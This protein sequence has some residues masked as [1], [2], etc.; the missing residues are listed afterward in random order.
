MIIFMIDSISFISLVSSICVILFTIIIIHKNS[1]WIRISLHILWN[2]G[3]ILIIFYSCVLYFLTR[4]DN[5]IYDFLYLMDREILKTNT[6]IFFNKCLNT[7]ESDLK[8]VLYLYD[9]NSVLIDIDRYYKNIYPILNSLTYFE[10]EIP[11]LDN[12]K[13]ISNNFNKYLN[14]YKLSTNATYEYS[15]INFVLNEISKITNNSKNNNN[16]ENKNDFFCESNDI[17]VSSKAKCKDFKYI[18][19]YDLHNKLERKKE[20][21]YCFIIQDNYQPSDLELIYGNI[22]TK[23]AYDQL[24]N[25]IMGLTKYYN[26]NENLLNSLEK[27]FKELERYNKKLSNITLEQINICKK[28]ISELT[29]IYNPILGDVNITYLFRCGGLKRK[30][31]NFYDIN[32][33]QSIYNCTFIKILLIIIILLIFFGNMIIIISNKEGKEIKQMKRKYLKVEN[34][35]INNDGVELIEEVPGEDEDN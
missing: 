25:F 10:H 23:K 27:I 12:I 15:D 18:S 29:D 35:D 19:R 24:I 14:N 9:K 22:C 31:L 8:D 2:I 33:N 20:D 16:Q 6:N 30:I 17:W 5:V 1:T 7:E 28:D 26:S 21:K 34:K 11:K 3:F 13:K 4:N 32:Y